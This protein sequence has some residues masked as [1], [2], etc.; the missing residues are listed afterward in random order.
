MHPQQQTKS[1]Q[2]NSVKV[3]GQERITI[4]EDITFSRDNLH[5][6]M[7]DDKL[8]S[9]HPWLDCIKNLRIFVWIQKQCISAENRYALQM[10]V[11]FTL[12]SLFVIVGPVSDIFPNA[13]WVGKVLT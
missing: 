4:V 8:S 3:P 11:A 6:T 2:T 1:E 7:R 13:F 10:S 9:R 5:Q 12:A